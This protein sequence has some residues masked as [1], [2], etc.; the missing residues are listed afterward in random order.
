MCGLGGVIREM[1][2]VT[3]K[4]T[5]LN[6]VN[7]SNSNEGPALIKSNKKKEEKD[8]GKYGG[9]AVYGMRE[10]RDGVSAV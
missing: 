10:N 1:S 9:L 2:V 8:K 6:Q 4:V 5:D 7:E 3:I